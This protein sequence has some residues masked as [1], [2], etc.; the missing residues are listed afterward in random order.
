[1]PFGKHNNKTPWYAQGLAFECTGCG[2]CCAGPEEGYV[3][4]TEDDITAIAA[5]LRIPLNELMDKY[6]RKVG[7]RFSLREDPKTKDCLFLEAADNG[8]RKC[9]IYAHRPTQCLTWPFW[10]SNVS[11]PDHWAMAGA[12]CEGINRGKLHKLEEIEIRCNATH[13]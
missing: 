4:I 3:W 6:V 12:R 9:T 5:H 8:Q 1:V 13:E 7:K 10:P 11:N 2:G